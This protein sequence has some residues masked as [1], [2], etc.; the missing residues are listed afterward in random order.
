M[1]YILISTWSSPEYEICGE[2]QKKTIVQGGFFFTSVLYLFKGIKFQFI[3]IMLEVKF[4]ASSAC[5]L[6]Q[7]TH[8][9]VL[10]QWVFTNIYSEWLNIS[11]KK[12]LTPFLKDHQYAAGYAED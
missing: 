11:L 6:A 10:L 7:L 8:F 12:N 3:Q 9:R 5:H 1:V 2:T 4:N